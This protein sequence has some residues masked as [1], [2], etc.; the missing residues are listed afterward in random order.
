MLA[1]IPY[2]TQQRGGYFGFDRMCIPSSDNQQSLGF[3][4]P[5]WDM[6]VS[7]LGVTVLWSSASS[8]PLLHWSGTREPGISREPRQSRRSDKNW[9]LTHHVP[10]VIHGQFICMDTKASRLWMEICF[11]FFPKLN[12]ERFHPPKQSII[13][14]S[15][16]D[17]VLCIVTYIVLVSF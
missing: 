17:C 7:L 13:S 16:S 14:I 8:E 2:P 5:V 3:C 10:Q 6:G 9:G 11:R 1:Y 15:P 4:F 12:A